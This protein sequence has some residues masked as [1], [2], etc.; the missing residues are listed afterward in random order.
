MKCGFKFTNPRTT[1]DT[2]HYFYPDSA[3]YYQPQKPEKKRNTL[4]NK[5][6]KSI[7]VNNYNYCLKTE[8]SGLIAAIV[9]FFYRKRIDLTH[10]P[11]FLKNVRLLDIG[12]SYGLYINKM[13]DLGWNTYGIEIN[14]KAV[15]FTRKE[16]SLNN[17]KSGFF[18]DIKFRKDFFDVVHMG[19]ALEHVFN[20]KKTLIKINN[21]LKK[22][23]QIILSIPDIDGFEMKLYKDKCYALHIPQHL[24]HFNPKTI[25]FIMEKTGF[26]VEKI[27]HQNFDRDIVASA[28]YLK[29]KFIYKIISNR[30]IRKTIVKIFINFLSLIGKSSRMTIYGR[31]ISE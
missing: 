3:G 21:I 22:N 23:G 5:I 20:P 19:M 28:G 17:I 10:M 1:K 4:K 26:K 16:L 13:K 15:D 11:F 14:K 12:C 6:L 9:Y 18:E 2:I 7:L 24:N 29:N 8:Y 27:I 25:R 30:V 31:K